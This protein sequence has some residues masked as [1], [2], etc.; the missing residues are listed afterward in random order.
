[1]EDKIN[2]LRHETN[3]AVIMS[4]SAQLQQKEQE[5]EQYRMALQKIS[6]SYD[7]NCADTNCRICDEA[8]HNIALIALRGAN[9]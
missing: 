1:M 3:I 5:L 8:P 7:C 2:K 4:L 9:V 6:K